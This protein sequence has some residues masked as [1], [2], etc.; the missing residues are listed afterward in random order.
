M[1]RRV[2]L[3]WV[4]V[5]VQGIYVTA[6]EVAGLAAQPQQPES[7]GVTAPAAVAPSATAVTT[8]AAG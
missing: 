3:C 1:W 2:P 6:R 5:L 7:I 8:C 4:C